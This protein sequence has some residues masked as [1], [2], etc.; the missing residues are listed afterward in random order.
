MCIHDMCVAM[1]VWANLETY[2]WDYIEWRFVMRLVAIGIL[3]SMDISLDDFYI[4]M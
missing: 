1:Y 2:V 3:K 4:N